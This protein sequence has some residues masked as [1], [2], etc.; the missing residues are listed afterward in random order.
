MGNNVFC[1]THLIFE[2]GTTRNSAEYF[3]VRRIAPESVVSEAKHADS[4]TH[5]LSPSSPFPLPFSHQAVTALVRL[6]LG[7]AE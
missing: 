5:T 7:G 1:M 6:E 3:N 2:V 4:Y